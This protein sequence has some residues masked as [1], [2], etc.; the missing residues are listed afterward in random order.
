MNIGK[1]LSKNF[2]LF[3][4]LNA[5]RVGEGQNPQQ[6]CLIDLYLCLFNISEEIGRVASQ[7][8]NAFIKYHHCL[9]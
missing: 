8:I 6:K 4:P 7:I 2:F 9:V 1:M 5:R 3:F